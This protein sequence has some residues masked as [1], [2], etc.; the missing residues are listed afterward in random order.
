MAIHSTG[1]EWEESLEKTGSMTWDV[2]VRYQAVGT[3]TI[4]S[5]TSRSQDKHILYDAER[6][7]TADH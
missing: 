4:D 2:T 3:G 5:T 1:K 7:R 6:T